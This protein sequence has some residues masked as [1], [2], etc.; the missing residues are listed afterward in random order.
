VAELVDAT[1]LGSVRA[2]CGGSTPF[3][4]TTYF[5][6][7]AMSRNRLALP[8]RAEPNGETRWPRAARTGPRPSLSEQANASHAEGHQTTYVGGIC[9]RGTGR[10]VGFDAPLN[11]IRPFAIE[12]KRGRDQQRPKITDDRE[13]ISGIVRR[14]ASSP[15][16]PHDAA[17]TPHAESRAPRILLRQRYIDKR[18]AMARFQPPISRRHDIFRSVSMSTQPSLMNDR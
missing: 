15:M 12:F 8:R 14:S 9:D 16:L 18:A 1:D 11:S 13:A 7:Q 2:T 6:Y 10:R 17:R 3:D 4:R 5:I